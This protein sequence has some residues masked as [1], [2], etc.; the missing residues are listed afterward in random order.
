MKIAVLGGGRVGAALADRWRDAGHEVA[1]STR[2]TVAD[3]ARGADVVV[4]AVPAAAAA[5]VLGQAG[6]LEG[7]VLVD[8]T[9]NLSGGPDAAEIARLAGGAPVVKAF[10]TVFAQFFAAPPEWPA[11][12]VIAGADTGAKETAAR[13]VRDAGFDPVDAGGD[14]AVP[15]VEAFARLVIGIAYR[16]GRGPFV[17]RFD[18]P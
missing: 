2:D 15:L 9:N 14:D 5:D 6:D 13:L 10:N 18:G 11:S 8:A 12:L 3:T 7:A 1:V 4:L 16:Q 17:Y